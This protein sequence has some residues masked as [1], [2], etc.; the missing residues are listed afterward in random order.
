LNGEDR[1]GCIPC[2]KHA[3]AGIRVKSF[4]GDDGQG[5]GSKPRN[6]P[7]RL[8]TRQA[9]TDFDGRRVFGSVFVGSALGGKL[10]KFRTQAAG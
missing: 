8:D 9:G 1:I 6:V 5:S 4:G 2:Q 7:A 3:A 10:P